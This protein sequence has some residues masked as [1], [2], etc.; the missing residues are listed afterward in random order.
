MMFD[1][2]DA[3][4]M[5]GA[6]STLSR[7][8][9]QRRAKPT[10][11]IEG[12]G[13]QGHEGA[14][15][16][17]FIVHVALPVPARSQPSRRKARI[18]FLA[19]PPADQVMLSHHRAVSPGPARAWLCRGRERQHRV[20]VGEGR[21]ERLTGLVRQRDQGRCELQPQYGAQGDRGSV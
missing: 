5:Q 19:E 1:Q 7:Y 10:K 11:V 9:V 6:K 15:L 16:C 20:S 17:T 4:S 14:N 18:G 8:W 21:H 13:G 12:H 2:V 3:P